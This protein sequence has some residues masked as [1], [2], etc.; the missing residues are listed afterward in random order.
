M[1]DKWLVLCVLI[2]KVELVPAGGETIRDINRTS[3]AHVELDRNPPPNMG[4]KLFNI[5]GNP[6][7][8]QHAIQLICE[9]T[10]MQGPPGGPPGGPMGPGPGGPGPQGPG[11]QGPGPQGPGFDQF[12]QYGQPK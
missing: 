8:I 9:K 5:R 11:P 7:Q 3:G 10:G 6:S 4:E 2:M 1:F 12:G